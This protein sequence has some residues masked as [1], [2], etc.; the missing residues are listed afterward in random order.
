MFAD[1]FPAEPYKENVVEVAHSLSSHTGVRLQ[2]LLCLDFDIGLALFTWSRRCSVKSLW[3]IDG[4]G[5][6]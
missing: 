4:E 3:S 6:T 5:M 2:A 1:L